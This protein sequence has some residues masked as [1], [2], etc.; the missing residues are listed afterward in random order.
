MKILIG[1]GM[2]LGYFSARDAAASCIIKQK[3][4]Q[5]AY[6]FTYNI[7]KQTLFFRFVNLTGFKGN[8]TSHFMILFPVKNCISH[9]CFKGM[10]PKARLETNQGK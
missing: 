7:K 9:I 5:F 4:Q 1:P 10:Q 2:V 8:K 3:K 6:F